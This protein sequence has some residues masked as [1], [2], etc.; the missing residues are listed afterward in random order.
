MEE[1]IALHEPQLKSI[2]FPGHLNVPLFE[3]LH[4][5][6]DDKKVDSFFEIKKFENSRSMLIAKQELNVGEA[7][8]LVEHLWKNDGGKGAYEK[9]EKNPELTEKLGSMFNIPP[10]VEPVSAFD[11]SREIDFLSSLCNVEKTDAEKE[12]KESDYDTISTLMKLLDRDLK[13]EEEVDDKLIERKKAKNK[14]TYEEFKKALTYSGHTSGNENDAYMQRMYENFLLEADGHGNT[15]HYNWSDDG[16]SVVVFVSIPQTTRKQAVNSTLTTTSWRLVV[17]GVQ[18]IKGDFYAHVKPDECYWSIEAPG[19]LCMTMEKVSTENLWPELIKG[20]VGLSRDTIFST[21]FLKGNNAYLYWKEILDRMWSYNLM[22][23][24]MASEGCKKP[25]WYIMDKYGCALSHALDPNFQCSP[26]FN[27]QTGET[28][29]LLWPIKNILKGSVCTRN[30]IP[31][32]MPGETAEMSKSRLKSFTCKRIYKDLKSS[33]ETEDEIDEKKV[34]V[35]HGSKETTLQDSKA[36]KK[37]VWL[38]VYSDAISEDTASNFEWYIAKSSEATDIAL[39]TLNE[40]SILVDGDPLPAV[41]VF[42]NKSFLQSYINFEHSGNT[43][44]FQRSYILPLSLV[45]FCCEVETTNL[46]RFWVVRQVD[47]R[48]VD[49]PTVVSSSYS[50]IVRMCEG[51]SIAV[52]KFIMDQPKFRH[53]RFVLNY[54][55]IV[56]KKEN[57]IFIHKEPYIH[58]TKEDYDPND[59]IC[60][61]DTVN[62]IITDRHDPLVGNQDSEAFKDF[63]AAMNKLLLPKDENFGFDLYQ[64]TIFQTI[65]KLGKSILKDLVIERKGFNYVAFGTD[66]IIDSNLAPIIID[67]NGVCNPPNRSNLQDI[68]SLMSGTKMDSFVKIV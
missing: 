55:V 59:L 43:P 56:N 8:F 29:N 62:D 30:F 6:K 21:S 3:R 10:P 61:Y 53:R 47:K 13:D 52:S 27:V 34:Q 5:E 15:L 50:R 24:L 68:F 9:L 36:S 41:E 60:E 22:Y 16:S 38:S 63:Q 1:F 57:S 23:A 39:L 20:E 31:P 40:A 44:W 35:I 66:L 28:Y 32:I 48:L 54:T 37:S 2:G 12:L 49:V 26:F 25:V 19:V 67:V 46:P 64:N 51:G 17:N 7:F 58:T 42:T 45:E 65:G 18:I 33:L 11:A 14:A 4:Q